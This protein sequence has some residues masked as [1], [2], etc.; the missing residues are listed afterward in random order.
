MERSGFGLVFGLQPYLFNPTTDGHGWTR[1]KT[2]QKV[3]SANPEGLTY[4]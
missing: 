3:S 4:W 2:G 1:I